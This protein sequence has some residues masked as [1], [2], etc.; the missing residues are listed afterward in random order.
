MKQY[1]KQ[2]SLIKKNGLSYVGPTHLCDEYVVPHIRSQVCIPGIWPRLKV[3]GPRSRL[4]V[5]SPRYR[6]RV[7]VSVCGSRVPGPAYRSRV[8]PMGPESRVL[9]LRWSVLGPESHGLTQLFFWEYC[10]IL[11]NF[12]GKNFTGNLRWQLLTF[13]KNC[14]KALYERN[15]Y[16]L[17]S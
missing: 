9:D 14:F 8:T 13:S 4:W 1:K 7:P 17:L 12:Y 2:R 3:P 10:E 6:P 16:P 15:N 5:P 11:K